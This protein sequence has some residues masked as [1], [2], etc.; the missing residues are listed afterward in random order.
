MSKF[1]LS[2]A[3]AKA[4]IATKAFFEKELILSRV[5][6]SFANAVLTDTADEDVLKLEKEKFADSDKASSSATGTATVS[7]LGS[8]PP[9]AT[10]QS[11]K[12]ISVCRAIPVS[13]VSRIS[14]RED[15]KPI[16]KECV[17]ALAPIK[18]LI[19]AV[20]SR[21]GA[22]RIRKTAMKDEKGKRFGDLSAPTVLHNV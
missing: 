6:I 10:C 4:C 21:V 8:Y 17:D 5:V 13:L 2:Q 20:K 3:S 22:M 15:F 11:L 9:T 1:V 7:R 12:P 18:D 19:A 16:R 14:E